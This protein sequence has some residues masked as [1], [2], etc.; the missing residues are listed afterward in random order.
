MKALFLIAVFLIG[1]LLSQMDAAHADARYAFAARELIRLQVRAASDGPEDQALKLRV[2]DAVR[3]EAALI[4]GEA[5]TS[6]EAFALLQGAKPR[7][8]QAAFGAAKANGFEGAVRIE[9]AMV[10]FPLR[11]YGE[12][13]VPPGD[14]RALRVT[15]GEGKGRNWWC[16]VYPDLCVTDPMAAEALRRSEPIQFYSSAWRLIE[17]WLGV[18]DEWA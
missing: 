9:T 1:A 6:D 16:V 5:R 4:A 18:Y 14:Y 15:L 8:F 13:P 2:R 3:A 12:L 10:R 7:L 17:R 11:L